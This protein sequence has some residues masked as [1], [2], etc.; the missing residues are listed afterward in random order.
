M[1]SNYIVKT[2]PEVLGRWRMLP[3]A[4]QCFTNSLKGVIIIMFAVFK[5]SPSNFMLWYIPITACVH[6]IL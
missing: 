2:K 1:V 5:I 4:S 6:L 3:P